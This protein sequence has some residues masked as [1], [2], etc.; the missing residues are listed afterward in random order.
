[1]QGAIVATRVA[2]RAPLDLSTWREP[3]TKA[4]CANVTQVP[5]A[6]NPLTLKRQKVGIGN[7]RKLTYGRVIA[8]ILC[9][10]VTLNICHHRFDN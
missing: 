9:R 8:T 3:H 1:M 5:G 4:L 2:T 10:I 6:G 7:R